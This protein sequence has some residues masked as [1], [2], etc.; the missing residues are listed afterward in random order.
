MC[1]HV[2][3]Q[4]REQLAEMVLSLA[5]VGAGIKLRSSGLVAVTSAHGTTSLAPSLNINQVFWP[6]LHTLKKT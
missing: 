3:V 4:V 1:T 2:Q 5:R 6:S